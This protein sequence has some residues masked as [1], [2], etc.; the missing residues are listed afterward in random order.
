MQAIAWERSEVFK[1]I[2]K[3]NRFSYSRTE[4]EGVLHVN[5]KKFATIEQPW[6]PNPTGAVGGLPFRSCIPDGIY[7]LE[8]WRRP[9][10]DDV[11]LIFNPALGVYRL[12]AD[13]EG[14]A[15]R[16]LCL[17]HKGNFV[18]DIQGCI[19]PG[20]VRL[21]LKKHGVHE[22]AV[23]SSGAAMSALRKLLGTSEHVLIITN[24][25]GATDDNH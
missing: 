23:G 6:A 22:P 20:L 21:P 24:N 15:G 11:W 10:G 2:L 12:P 16:D 3:L 13:H 19:A 9:N 7:R 8:P 5:G 17:I 4:T 25:C 14:N 18:T 1:M